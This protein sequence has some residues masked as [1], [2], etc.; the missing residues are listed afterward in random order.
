MEKATINL[1]TKQLIKYCSNGNL[2]NEELFRKLSLINRKSESS[3]HNVFG[4]RKF[5]DDFVD[6][7]TVYVNEDGNSTIK[8]S[9]DD[10]LIKL[11]KYLN[12]S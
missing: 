6:R 8:L 12:I 1:N 3:V 2:S 4:Y 10:F 7:V 11:F 9:Y 5:N